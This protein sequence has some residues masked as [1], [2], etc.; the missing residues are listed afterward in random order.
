MS[1]AVMFVVSAAG[2]AAALWAH[3]GA[4][5]AMIALTALAFACG[6]LLGSAVS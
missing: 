6:L 3:P 5:R 4:A 2:I 1:A